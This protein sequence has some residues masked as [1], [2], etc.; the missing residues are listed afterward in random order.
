M[1][2]EDKTDQEL[3]LKI[4]ESIKQNLGEDIRTRPF[5][6]ALNM[7]T[8]VIVEKCNIIEGKEYKNRMIGLINHILEYFLNQQ[9]RL[10]RE[11]ET[12][13]DARAPN[14]GNEGLH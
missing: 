4:M 5:I 11:I 14:T 2:E 6:S 13:N 9:E 8:M 10:I 3:V 12:E 7:L 1:T